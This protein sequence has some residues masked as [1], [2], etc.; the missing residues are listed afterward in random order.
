MICG[1]QNPDS[2]FDLVFR[3]DVLEHIEPDY[4]AN[5]LQDINDYANKYIWL[6]IDTKPARKELSRWQKC[7]FN[8]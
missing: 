6:R 7:T 4:I 8:N 5:V 2:A 3:N 1:A